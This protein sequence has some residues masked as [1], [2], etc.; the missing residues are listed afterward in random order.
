MNILCINVDVIKYIDC[1][2]PF[3]SRVL[4]RDLSRPNLR[5]TTHFHPNALGEP[6]E[7][8]FYS[9]VNSQLQTKVRHPLRSEIQTIAP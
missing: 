7:S 6:V 8:F 3:G 9:V 2:R 1:H 5:A 4:I